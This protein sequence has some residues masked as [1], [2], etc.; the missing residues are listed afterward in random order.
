MC[1][2]VVV[3]QGSFEGYFAPKSKLPGKRPRDPGLQELP[4]NEALN[5]SNTQPNT[6]SGWGGDSSLPQPK[7]SA[8]SRSM[9]ASHGSLLLASTCSN[10]AAG[11]AVAAAG[12]APTSFVGLGLAARGS[13]GAV[14]AAPAAAQPMPPPTRPRIPPN[15]NIVAM[16]LGP[17]AGSCMSWASDS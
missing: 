6:N 14:T 16:I 8:T 15:E 5:G 2:V 13:S 11:G 4:A 10:Q 1:L 17:E 12:A 9:D 3:C 7:R